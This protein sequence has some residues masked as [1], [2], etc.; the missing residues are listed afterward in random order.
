[1]QTQF[2]K[3]LFQ[4]MLGTT[5]IMLLDLPL[6]IIEMSNSMNQSDP[7]NYSFTIKKK[8]LRD[9]RA[10]ERLDGL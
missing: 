8:K 4:L 10:D 3:H 6:W 2:I 9:K 1:M 7:R 5:N